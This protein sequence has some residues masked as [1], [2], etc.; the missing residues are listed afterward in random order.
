MEKDVFLL[1]IVQKKTFFV[2]KTLS[3]VVEDSKK[4]REKK[5]NIQYIDIVSI[6]RSSV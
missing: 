4:R 5:T 2:S 6:L 1:F 3:F